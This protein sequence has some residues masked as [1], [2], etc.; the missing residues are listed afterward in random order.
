MTATQLTPD[1]VGIGRLFWRIP[2]AV[3]V[4]DAAAGTIELWNPA[5]EALFGYPA[6]AI[7]GRLLETLVP[8]RLRPAHRAG[9][10]RFASTGTGPLVEGG[11]AVEMPAL[12]RDGSEVWVEMRLSPVDHEGRH[13]V[14]ALIRDLTDRRQLERERAM[15][16]HLE[17]VLLTART[18]EH[19]LNTKLTASIGYAQLLARDPRLPE[20]LRVRADRAAE[21]SREAA[22]IIKRLLQL[23]EVNVIDWADSGHTTIDISTPPRPSEPRP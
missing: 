18:F 12:K 21:G 23:T 3:I 15:K 8:E 17:G 6:E 7:V 16:A 10:A 14:L 1:D 9:L 13:L 5:A 2:D 11:Q 19:E 20:P 22:D 4:G